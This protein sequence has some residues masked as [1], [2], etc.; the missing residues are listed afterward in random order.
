LF[1]W[2]NRATKQSI[3]KTPIL[4]IRLS[5]GPH[6]SD[7]QVS[8]DTCIIRSK[9]DRVGVPISSH[10]EVQ[11]FLEPPQ[12]PSY[13]SHGAVGSS[14][15]KGVAMSTTPTSIVEGFFAYLTARD[16]DDLR[17]ILSQ[18]V[19]RVGPFADTITGRDRY[20]DFLRG[21]V[22]SEYQNE[23]RRIVAASDGRA[24]FARVTEHLRYGEH[25]HSLE[26]AYSF[27][28]GDDGLISRVEIYWQ[29]PGNEPGGFGSAASNDSYASSVAVDP[30]SDD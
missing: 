28:I 10:R 4:L 17:V 8:A 22:P 1:N 30:D 16:W 3:M 11:V 23:V 2:M 21:T 20:L 29:T 5:M 19:E 25:E 13:T 15:A 9:I 14:Q 26:E 7:R 6:P 12:L 24:A 18:D 27:D